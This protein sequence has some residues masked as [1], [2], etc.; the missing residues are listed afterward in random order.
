MRPQPLHTCLS[1][2]PH[3]LAVRFN[4]NLSKNKV[5]LQCPPYILMREVIIEYAFDLL[6][7]T[8]S[9]IFIG[10][11]VIFFKLIKKYINTKLVL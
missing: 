2:G 9:N 10:F 6:I 7:G 5:Y 4:F 1:D 11:L 8:R 3:L